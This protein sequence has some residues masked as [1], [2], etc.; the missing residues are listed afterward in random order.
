MKLE[1]DSLIRSECSG[2]DPGGET[3]SGERLHGDVMANA[4][5]INI[6]VPFKNK[7]QGALAGMFLLS[8]EADLDTA[9]CF[10][11]QPGETAILDVSF[12]SAVPQ[13]RVRGT[14]QIRQACKKD[15]LVPDSAGFRD[16]VF[17]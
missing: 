2:S 4:G 3:I 10:G 13:N 8:V 1:T 9:R 7:T 16:A 5:E 15:C 17:H 14:L 12:E 6:G 11:N